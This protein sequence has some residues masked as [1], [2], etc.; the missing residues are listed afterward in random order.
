MKTKPLHRWTPVV[1]SIWMSQCVDKPVFL[2]MECGQRTGS[3]KIRGIGRLCQE[4]VAQGK[5]HL[6]S[7]SGGNAGY[8]VAYAGRQMGIDVTVFVPTTTNEI[9][10]KF[11]QSQGANVVIQGSF[12]DEAD[13][14]AQVYVKE[15][16]GGFVP[17]FDHPSIWAGHSTLVDELVDQ[18]EKP[19][20]IVV[21]VGGGGLATGI[22]QG[23]HRHGWDDVPL[24]GVEVEGAPK[25][26]ESI[27]QNK[28]IKLSQVNTIATTLATTRITEEL[29]KWTKKH[30]ITP[31]LA[32]DK[33]SVKACR[34]FVDDQHVLVE[35]ACGAALSVV[36]NNVPEL[37]KADSILVIVCGGVGISIDLLNGYLKRFSI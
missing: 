9:F 25:L 35:P 33:A 8:S 29:F 22:L 10:I 32:S 12:W 3:F 28:L 37:K 30:A 27:K 17:P 16:D 5:T 6:V 7:S 21:S 18:T 11:I 1:E 4:W 13:E 26:Y 24:F 36:Y 14:A 15:I 34:Q 23:L 31:L 19:G 20:G 2:K